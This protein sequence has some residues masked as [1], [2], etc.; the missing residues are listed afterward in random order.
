MVVPIAMLAEYII[1]GRVGGGEGKV[2]EEKD[3]QGTLGKGE[4]LK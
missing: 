1:I 2:V 3:G 4:R